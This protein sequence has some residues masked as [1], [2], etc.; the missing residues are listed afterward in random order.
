MG[1]RERERE[2]ECS[3]ALTCS[4]FSCASDIRDSNV[5]SFEDMFAGTLAVAAATGAGAGA[6]ACGAV[7]RPARGTA[8]ATDEPCDA[9]EELRT[10]VGERPSSASTA[11]VTK[12]SRPT[13]PPAARHAA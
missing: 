3:L 4:V 9:P 6:G 1:E 13:R 7:S 11:M 5:D 12:A 2:E 8:C 10:E